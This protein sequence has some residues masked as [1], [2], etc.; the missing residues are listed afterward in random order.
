[1]GLSVKVCACPLLLGGRRFRID[2]DF[3][4]NLHLGGFG[5]EFVDRL[6]SEMDA[7]VE[8]E[9]TGVSRADARNPAVLALN[10]AVEGVASGGLDS[11]DVTILF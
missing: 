8:S 2:F 3:G 4:R 6:F 11:R 9:G 1:M 5:N 7:E 10:L